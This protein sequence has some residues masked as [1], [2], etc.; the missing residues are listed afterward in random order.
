MSMLCITT[1][2]IFSM[3]QDTSTDSDAISPA[4]I[5][6][7][8]P[9]GSPLSSPK[10]SPRSPHRTDTPP[11]IVYLQHQIKENKKN[12]TSK[13]SEDRSLIKKIEDRVEEKV[14]AL[15]DILHETTHNIAAG[16]HLLKSDDE[17]QAPDITVMHADGSPV[18]GTIITP[19]TTPPA[20]PPLIPVQTDFNAPAT[21]NVIGATHGSS[22]SALIQNLTK[23]LSV[24]ETEAKHAVSTT[25]KESEAEVKDIE[26][27][28]NDIKKAITEIETIE[29]AIY[30]AQKAPEIIKNDVANI[31]AAADTLS[32]VQKKASS[33]KIAGVSI[34]I[35][36][37]IAILYHLDRLPARIMQILDTY[38]PQF[39]VKNVSSKA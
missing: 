17:D 6:K 19:I 5:R 18:Q 38:L 32:S 3:D 9:F 13:T 11:A 27:T 31:K 4:P 8:T 22:E 7:G 34:S 26:T 23:D 16:L 39:L 29:T 36:A 33:L 10:R 1:S 35:I 28:K 20:T 14:D 37:L 21:D 30:I 25:K 24:L 12:K 2:V 15:K